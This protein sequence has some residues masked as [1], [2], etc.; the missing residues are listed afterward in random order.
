MHPFTLE[1]PRDVA[2]AM[3]LGARGAPAT[4]YIAGGTDMLPLLKDEVL[5]PHAACQ[6]LGYKGFRGFTGTSHIGG[7]P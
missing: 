2:T 6:R 7:W 4:E 3:M 5:R 1:R